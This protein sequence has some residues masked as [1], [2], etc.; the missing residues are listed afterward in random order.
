VSIGRLSECDVVVNDPGA[1]RRHAEVRSDNGRYVLTDLGST[2]GTKV[3]EA[4][5]TERELAPGDRITIGHTV[6]EFRRA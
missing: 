4:T 5:I 2:N 3:N 1:S 6:L